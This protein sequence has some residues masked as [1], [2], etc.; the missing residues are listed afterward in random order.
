LK[1]DKL[2]DDTPLR[3]TL[4]VAK[5]TPPKATAVSATVDAAPANGATPPGDSGASPPAAAT[6]AAPAAARAS[7][8]PPVG[9]IV[10]RKF[11]WPGD[12]QPTLSGATPVVPAQLGSTTN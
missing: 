9:A 10:K 6:P 5:K 3:P 11:N 7:A 12:D 2:P 1:P 8:A 4:A